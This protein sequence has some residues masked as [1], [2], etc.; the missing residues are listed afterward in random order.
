MSLQKVFS[1]CAEIDFATVLLIFLQEKTYLRAKLPNVSAKAHVLD[2][3]FEAVIG[4]FVNEVFPRIASDC[5]ES[6][7]VSHRQLIKMP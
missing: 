4:T 2:V 1:R 3:I 5:R 7:G 6:L